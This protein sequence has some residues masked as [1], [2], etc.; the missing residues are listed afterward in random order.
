ML[1]FE[2]DEGTFDVTLLT[3]ED[4]MFKLLSTNGDFQLGGTHFDQWVQNYMI[5][6]FN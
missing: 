4:G 6:I 5:Y 2:H 1:D 3:I